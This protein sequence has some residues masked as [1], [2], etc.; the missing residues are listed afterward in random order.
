[1]VDSSHW[2][3][4]TNS[5]IMD[6][7]LRLTHF[8]RIFIGNPFFILIITLLSLRYYFDRERLEFRVPFSNIFNTARKPFMSP[9]AF[10]FLS[11][12]RELRDE[13]YTYLLVFDSEPLALESLEAFG[14]GPSAY[15]PFG[16]WRR[17]MHPILAQ[18]S[19]DLS[20]FRVSRQVHQEASEIFFR[21]NVFPI[22]I[23]VGG[24]QIIEGARVLDYCASSRYM[25]PWE[26]ITYSSS[27][28]KPAGELGMKDHPPYGQYLATYLEDHD[29]EVNLAQ[30]YRHLIRKIRIEI[31]DSDFVRYS[32]GP[33]ERATGLTISNMDIRTYLMPFALRLKPLLEDKTDEL[34][35]DL[36][37]S[38]SVLDNLVDSNPANWADLASL[39]PLPPA[40]TSLYQQMVKLGGPFLWLNPARVRI[41]TPLELSPGFAQIQ[42]SIAGTIQDCMQAIN[43]PEASERIFRPVKLREGCRFGKSGGVLRVYHLKPVPGTGEFL[44]S[45][46]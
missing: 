18:V 32:S 8:I 38:S 22:K 30:C 19:I 45:D 3:P 21:R 23:L 44:P 16:E 25:A 9:R 26:D 13:I 10:P 28:L 29:S 15:T 24:E 39:N 36:R 6:A 5:E 4:H 33:P 2:P 35:I 41:R 34:H 46:G 40:A 1:M 42:E 17:R 27:E 37:I 31:I 7:I 11:L 12:P 43:D 20:L 14:K